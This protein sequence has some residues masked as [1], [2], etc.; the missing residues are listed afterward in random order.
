[1]RHPVDGLHLG[2][3]VFSNKKSHLCSPTFFSIKLN[4]VGQNLITRPFVK[5]GRLFLSNTRI[6]EEFT[7]YL[8]R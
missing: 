6:V 8:L 4:L 3:D 1:M 2:L 5:Y 7:R